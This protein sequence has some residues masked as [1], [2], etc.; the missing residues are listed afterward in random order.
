MFSINPISQIILDKYNK[1]VLSMQDFGHGGLTIYN[2]E[3]MSKDL[4]A[5]CVWIQGKL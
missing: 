3:E 1:S 2:V 5:I 4:I